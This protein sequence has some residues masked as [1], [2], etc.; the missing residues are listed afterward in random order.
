MDIMKIILQ[1]NIS[2]ED[3]GS[4]YLGF[5]RKEY[6]SSTL[7]GPILEWEFITGGLYI[8]QFYGVDETDDG[9]YIVSGT[10]EDPEGVFSGI[11][12]KLDSNGNEQWRNISEG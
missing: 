11:V 8:D 12:V 3:S 4:A 1:V 10:I 5:M 9:G 7:V 2:C 6:Q